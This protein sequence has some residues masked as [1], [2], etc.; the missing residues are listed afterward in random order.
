[1]CNPSVWEW[2]PERFKVELQGH[3]LPLSELVANLG[4][5]R[6]HIQKEE[7]EGGER[8]TRKEE[9]KPIILVEGS[10]RRSNLN[11]LKSELD[12]CELESQKQNKN[13]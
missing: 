11:C 13:Q 2:K 1:M 4:C 7:R 10:T 8:E 9:K 6:P 5:T 3:H 12:K